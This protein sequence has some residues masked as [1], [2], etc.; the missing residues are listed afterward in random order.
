MKVA[1]LKKQQRNTSQ[2]KPFKFKFEE[3]TFRI[4]LKHLNIIIKELKVLINTIRKKKLFSDVLKDKI[5]KN[6][7]Q[8]L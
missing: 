1:I 5:I 7:V 2:K 8:F 6:L 4:S 3:F